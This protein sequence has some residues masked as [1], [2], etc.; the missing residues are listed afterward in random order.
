[1]KYKVTFFHHCQGMDFPDKRN[2]GE[3]DAANA[4]DAVEKILDASFLG[5]SPSDRE[6]I[7]GCLSAKMVGSF[8]HPHAPRTDDVIL[9]SKGDIAKMARILCRRILEPDLAHEEEVWQAE[10]HMFLNDV[11]AMLGLPEETEDGREI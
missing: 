4:E 5:C 6:Y 1:M 3:V 10:K 7:K 8:P 9:I 11:R 2:F